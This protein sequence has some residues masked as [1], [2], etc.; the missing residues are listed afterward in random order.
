MGCSLRIPTDK[1]MKRVEDYSKQKKQN[2]SEHNY[3]SFKSIKIAKKE[4]FFMY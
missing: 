4:V 1:E 2:V 3:C